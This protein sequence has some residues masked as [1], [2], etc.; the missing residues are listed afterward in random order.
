MRDH[1]NEEAK[2]GRGR[3]A[4]GI[5]GG[6]FLVEL[7][8]VVA[9]TGRPGGNIPVRCRSGHVFTTIWIPGASVKSVRMGLWRLQYCPVGGH[10][11]IV[12]P[13][14]ESSLSKRERRAAHKHH[15]IRVP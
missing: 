14:R 12:T 11:S 15:D 10:W 3:R 13:V 4:R 8:A 6:A 2:G 1:G 9:R 5:A 7:A